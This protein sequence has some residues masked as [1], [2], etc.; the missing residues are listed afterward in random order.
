MNSACYFNLY[1]KDAHKWHI[2]RFLE[3]PLYTGLIVFCTGLVLGLWCLT[4]LSMVEETG[5]SGEKTTDLSQVIDKLYH[6]MLYRL[7]LA[8]AGFEL[9]NW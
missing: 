5:I 8:W 7:H 3:C 4:P 6:I 2:V 9:T 1:I